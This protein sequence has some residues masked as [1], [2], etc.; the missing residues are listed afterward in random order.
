M[1]NTG[2][3]LAMRYSRVTTGPMYLIST[4]VVLSE[5]L[6]TAT[7]CPRPVPLGSPA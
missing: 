1:Q 2:L 4:A 5:L 7:W 6:K 3:V